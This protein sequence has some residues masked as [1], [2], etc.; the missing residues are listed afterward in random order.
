M[1]TILI[2]SNLRFFLILFFLFAIFNKCDEFEEVIPYVPVNIYIYID[3]PDY[4]TL[5][6]IGNSLTISGGLNGIIIYRKG[7]S[8]FV[9][10]EK[11]CTYQ[12]SEN[13]KVEKDDSGFILE[14]PCCK[15]QFSIAYG[16]VLKEP[17][18]YPL[19]QYRTSF[20]GSRINNYN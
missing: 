2:N 15:S 16:S 3:T 5:N 4:N 19:K 14:C 7:L 8:E 18:R 6:A 13:C 17:S 1:K 12:P 10:L 20:D 9:A 11:T